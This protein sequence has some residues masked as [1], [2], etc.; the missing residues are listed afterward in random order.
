MVNG[1]AYICIVNSLLQKVCLNLN[2]IR[3]FQW[4]SILCFCKT[5][6]IFL[7]MFKRW[8]DDRPTFVCVLISVFFAVNKDAKAKH[9][10]KPS[11]CHAED[12]WRWYIFKWYIALPD[13]LVNYITCLWRKQ[14]KMTWYNIF[15]RTNTELPFL[16]CLYWT[17]HFWM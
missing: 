1:T 6:W 3:S 10:F 15:Q 13:H 16:L 5:L 2:L 11:I 4:N 9:I 14:E 8:S 7:K 12:N 17:L